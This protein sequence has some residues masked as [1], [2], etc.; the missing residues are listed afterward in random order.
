MEALDAFAFGVV[1]DLHAYGV[2]VSVGTRLSVEARF[3][4]FLG[5][6]SRGKDKFN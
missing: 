6:K 2:G 3:A 4:Q 1:V 5:C